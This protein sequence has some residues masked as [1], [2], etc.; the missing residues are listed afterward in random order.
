MR[1]IKSVYLGIV[2][3][4]L[5]FSLSGCLSA[6]KDNEIDASPSTL[7]LDSPLPVDPQ[8]TIGRLNNGL[9]YYL[10][11]NGEPK[12]RA[13]LRL[14]VNAGS[15]LE[16]DNQK[17]LAHYLEHMAFNGTETFAPDEIVNYLESIGMR[18]GP[19][20][21]AS[22]GFD[23]TIY[24]LQVP[25]DKP[26]PLEKALQI[27]EEWAHRISFKEAEV[28]KE[29]GVIIE[30]WR[31]GRG[32]EARM[33]EAQN[34]VLFDGSL[35]A[36]R[37]P[38]GKLETIEKFQSEDFKKFY[39][40]WYR[41]DLMAV[42]AVGDFDRDWMEAQIK[43]Y[44][45]RLKPAVNPRPRPNYPVPDHPKTLFALASDKEATESR[46]SVITKLDITPFKTVGDYRAILVESL[47]HRMLNDRLHELTRS[48]E[49]PFL[50]GYSGQ[51]RFVRTKEFYILGAR[52]KEN[53]FERGLETL[54]T[55]AKRVKEF[56]FTL[57]ELERQK[58]DLL[59]GIEQVFRERDKRDSSDYVREYT[60]HYT[61]GE[62][63]PGTE[64][65][66]R[67]Y[68]TYVPEITL[69]EVNSLAGKWLTEENRVIMINS[70]QKNGIRIPGE[71]ELL[72]IFDRVRNLA[73][74]PYIDR[75][76][77][78][79]LVSVTPVPGTITSEKKIE[80]LDLTEWT[81]SN[82]VRLV[83]KPTDFKNDQVL[84]GSFSPGGNS[85][86][87]N[88]EYIAAVTAPR[89][90]IEGGLDGFSKIELEKK[91]TGKNVEVSPWINELYEGISGSGSPEDLET[92]LQLIY[93]YFTAPRMDENA[94]LAYRERLK[95]NLENRR[96]SPEENFWDTIR[97]AIDQ[98][99]YRSRPW[100]PEIISEMDLRESFD[101]YRNRFADASDFTFFL[102]GNFDPQGIKPL[103]ETY[104]GGLP[105]LRRNETWRDLGINP[106]EKIV[107]R[108]VKK[109]LEAKSQV[110]L[111]FGSPFKWSRKG[112]F[113]M[114]AVAE[115][116]DRR[117][118]ENLRED[119]GG[120][121]SVGVWSS[122]SRYPD[123]EIH[124]FIGFGCAPEKVNRLTEIVFE[125]I[126]TLQA[127][128]PIQKDLDTV[129]EILRRDR[130][131]NLR[132]NGFWLNV[133]RSY[134]MNGQ[135]PQLILDYDRLIDELTPQDVRDMTRLYLSPDRF[136][137]VVL[138]PQDWKEEI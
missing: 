137:K 8:V 104:L 66:Y 51:G 93:L 36:E 128:G 52:V 18:F 135:D 87:P 37:S 117:L 45:S 77:E 33:R 21:N 32:A 46:L 25:T 70:P 83:L 72:A 96:L 79:P 111:V 114:D 53:G 9:T 19:E 24:K 84:L 35:Y 105:A 60:D 22:T 71:S 121:Y 123:E 126:R 56:G 12:D 103:I 17:G 109:G 122:P 74:S 62:P 68:N 131:T 31:L 5:L 3:F 115:I 85:L 129:K 50:E 108:T 63:I 116:L 101:I 57:S 49:P 102:V 119:Q 47:Y 90:V 64:Y 76:S 75:V 7:K 98:D 4:V 95:E 107:E 136:V 106:P 92:M 118:R 94:Y 112:A 41:P 113:T 91:L 14:V 30:E 34:R 58:K 59:K 132:S 1:H 28:E 80:E 78:K 65:E 44:F 27:L 38:I 125:E 11:V 23:E 110:Q 130:E 29:R 99:H 127:N 133:L 48:P 2:L 10:L 134:Y 61:E 54:L 89:I 20:V 138:Y 40:D 13:S 82:G 39:R 6:G 100:T 42:I 26:E 97:S 15:V 86:V 55:E 124:V 16:E 120:T 88:G 73:V 43:K 67:L 81:L 69:E